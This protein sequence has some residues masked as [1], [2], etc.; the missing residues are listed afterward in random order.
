[1]GLTKHKTPEAAPAAV[2]TTKKATAAAVA[3]EAT[4]VDVSEIG[5]KSGTIAFVAP[6][7]DPSHADNTYTKG[8]NGENIKATTAY[9]VGYRFKALEDMTVPECGLDK[10]ATKNLMSYV[11]PNGTRQVKA[12]EEFNLTR[13]E[14]G[15]L[16]SPAFFPQLQSDPRLVLLRTTRLSRFFL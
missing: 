11:D 12:G 5:K 6:L 10:D 1:M 2:E 8:A 13:F 3:A 14:V 4:P 15:M 9:I 16:L 7:G